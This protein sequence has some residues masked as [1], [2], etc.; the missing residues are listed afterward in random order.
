[1]SRAFADNPE[2][3]ILDDSSSALDFA[4]ESKLRNA[5]DSNFRES[6]TIIIAQRISSVLS[7]KNII[8]LENGEIDAMGNHEYMLEHS[9]AYREIAEMQLGNSTEEVLY[10]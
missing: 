7:A 8:F 4:T 9:K 1:M 2:V 10:E 6:T 3:L 5:L